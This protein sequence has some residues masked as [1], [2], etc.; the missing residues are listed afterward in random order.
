MTIYCIV[1]FPSSLRVIVI[2]SFVACSSAF[3]FLLKQLGRGFGFVKISGRLILSTSDVLAVG[4]EW[5]STREFSFSWRSAQR[6]SNGWNPIITVRIRVR[7]W[8]GTSEIFLKKNIFSEERSTLHFENDRTHKTIESH[9][10]LRMTLR[11]VLRFPPSG[12]DIEC[13]VERVLRLCV[14]Q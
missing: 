14:V 3:S 7:A 5:V 2:T 13:N 4:A 12:R 8:G 11:T 6:Y 1:V 10:A 9:N